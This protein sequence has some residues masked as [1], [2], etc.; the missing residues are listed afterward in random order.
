MS[1]VDRL[2]RW[3]AFAVN[4][5]TG[6]P[7]VFLHIP[8]CGGTSVG[9]ALRLRYLLSQ[10]TVHPIHS[11][12]AIKANLPDLGDEELLGVVHEFR[13][14][15]LAYLISDRT[16]CISAH[17]PFS[18]GAWTMAAGEYKFVTILRD[19]VDRFVSHYFHSL[20]RDDYSRIELSL[21]EF[22]RTDRAR[23]LGSSYVEYLSGLPYGNDFSGPAAIAAAVANLEYFDKIGFLDRLP[24]FEKDLQTLLGIRLR[25]RHEN[26][27]S[28]GGVGYRSR[29]SA[30]TLRIVTELCAADIEVYT[31]ARELSNA[32]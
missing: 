13:Q 11:Y 27:G 22:V 5:A 1:L 23:R 24:T 26:V 16:R 20:N 18:K 28:H 25:I 31:A 14:R 19:P 4:A 17:V 21:D 7:V 15:M 12:R 6:K 9:R 10:N 32:A 3:Q 8:K 29:L 2:K 30:E